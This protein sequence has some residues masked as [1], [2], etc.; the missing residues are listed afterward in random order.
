MSPINAKS[1]TRSLLPEPGLQRTYVTSSFISTVGAGIIMPIGILYFTCIVGLDATR[2]GL[3]FMVAG[4]LAIPFSV[5]A[6]ELAD[7]VGPRRVA[8]VGL[9]G[10]SAAGVS[11]LFVQNFRTLLAA[12]RVIRWCCRS[13]HSWPGTY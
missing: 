3:A 10:L 1:L 5:P 4:L 6:G 9:A 12:E 13:S 7:R 2:V 8:M 11:F